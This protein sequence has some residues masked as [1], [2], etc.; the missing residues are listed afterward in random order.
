MARYSKT[1][2]ESSRKALLAAAAKL[3]RA[4]GFNGVGIDELCGG[5]ELTRG[6]FYAHFKSKRALFE[7]VLGGPHD[8]IERLR[9]RKPGK[10]AAGAVQ[11]ATDYLTPKHRQGVLGGC[12]LASLAMDTARSNAQAQEAYAA[13]VER[14]VAEFQREHPTLKDREARA[15]LALCVGCS[16]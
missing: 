5:A 9:A 3:F 14:I 1:H 16:R 7:S 13:A 2:K 12:S 11:V 8:F 6:A 10:L 15:A 4:K